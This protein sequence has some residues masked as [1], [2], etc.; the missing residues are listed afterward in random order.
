MRR[1]FSNAIWPSFSSALASRRST[2]LWAAILCAVAVPLCAQG[3]SQGE[4]DSRVQVLTSALNHAQ[5]QL[6]ESARQLADLRRQLA[7]LRQ[8]ITSAATDPAD[9]TGAQQLA[10]QVQALREE[11]AMQASEIATHQQDKV[12]SAS[13]YPVRLTGLVL[14]NGFV[15][16]HQV[17]M[18]ATPTVALAG[19]GSTGATFRQTILGLDAT[20]P[21]I[22][23]AHTYADLRA[24][25]FGAVAGS[26]AAGAYNTAG[27]FRLRTA[28]AAIAWENTEAFF[29]LDRPLINPNQ[30]S[31]LTA[32]AIPA[33]A[34]SGN[35]WTWNPQFGVRQ[36]IAL[37]S[38]ARL[39]MQAALVDV[40]DAPYGN[41]AAS[42]STAYLASSAEESRW[43]G[44]Q[45]RVAILG[46]EKQVGAQQGT[47]FQLGA[48]GYFAPHRTAYGTQFDS[49]AGSLDYRQPLPGRLEFSGNFY[50]GLALGGLGGG[51]YKDY[52][53]TQSITNPT[54]FYVRPFDNAGGWA[55]LKQRA[56][57]RLEFNAALGMDWI[58][59]GELYYY[60]G[61]A[62]A[63]YQNLARTQT[64]SGNVIFSPS[65]WLLFSLEYRHL[66]SWP[67]NAPSAQSNIIGVA[68][69]Y[70]F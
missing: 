65:A 69:G 31:S 28:H 14:F 51:A 46:S 59:S 49:W 26:G 15:N 43:P 60:T 17:D 48:G 7:D 10:A 58:P 32:V 64:F 56:T 42:N 18:P 20:G 6:E 33:L 70:K 62:T 11:Q 55:Q 66:E 16:T 63:F 53:V 29:A 2:L 27:L 67:V 44:V 19:A 24:D 37:S 35:L 3:P 4:L 34:W 36:D 40:A 39:R 25:F 45:A 13:K 12:E 54:R 1:S 52:G 41:N 5:D 47:G 8:Q 61:P 68:A 30:P 38:S 9:P 23:G 21:H 57:E 22:L 50:R